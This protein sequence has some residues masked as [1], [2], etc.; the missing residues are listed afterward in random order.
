MSRV[1]TTPFRRSRYSSR[2][3]SRAV[4][5]IL[6]P[7]RRTSRAAGSSSRSASER[8]VCGPVAGLRVIAQASEQLGEIERLWKVVV[9]TRIEPKYAVFEGAARGKHEHRRRNPPGAERPE[10]AEPVESRQQDVKNDRVIRPGEAHLE[11]GRSVGREV[12]DV[13]MLSQALAHHAGEL[14]VVFYDQNPQ[15]VWSPDR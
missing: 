3:N 1:T 8:T 7:P 6:R 14:R 10:N 12:H 13:A 9:G 2:A 4:S 11:A 15:I 5:S